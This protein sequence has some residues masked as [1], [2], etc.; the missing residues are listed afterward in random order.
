V[1]KKLNYR[2]GVKNIGIFILNGYGINILLYLPLKRVV[3]TEQNE[4]PVE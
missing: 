3:I 2:F 4:M 1:D